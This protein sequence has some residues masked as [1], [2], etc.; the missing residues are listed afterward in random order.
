MLTNITY[1]MHN[2][3]R[4]RQSPTI[5]FRFAPRLYHRNSLSPQFSSPQDYQRSRGKISGSSDSGRCQRI[6]GIFQSMT[7]GALPSA[8]KWLDSASNACSNY[9]V[10]MLCLAPWGG[11]SITKRLTTYCKQ[12][13]C[14]L[15][16][17]EWNYG[18]I[19]CK[20]SLKM[21]SQFMQ[22]LQRT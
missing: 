6:K 17:E 1:I 7:W 20:F 14:C 10:A 13:F 4:M 9:Q 19:A 5:C 8:L 3:F 22:F 12:H 18:D 15:C 2:H 11:V 21:L 16:K